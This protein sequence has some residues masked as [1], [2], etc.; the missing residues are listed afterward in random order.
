MSSPLSR[1]TCLRDYEVQ[2][3]QRL[4][5]GT[6]AYLNAGGAD[7]L[8]HIWNEQ[9]FKK[10]ALWPR[11][12]NN[13]G[14]GSTSLDLFGVRH[15]HPIFIA[16]MAYHGLA[17]AEAEHATAAAAAAMKAAFVVSTQASVPIEALSHR[18]AEGHLWFQLYLQDDRYVSL[19]LI[20]R[21]E[22]A[23]FKAIVITVDAPI[24]GSRNEDQR[25]AFQL[26]TA[27]QPVNLAPYACRQINTTLPAGASLF[28][29]PLIAQM[30]TWEAV[31]WLIRQ[32]RLPVLLKGILNPLDVAPALDTGAS[33]IVVSNHGGRVLDTLP[34]MLDCL[35][36]IVAEVRARVPVLADGGI[37]RGSDVFKA[38]ALGADAVL[39]GRP[40]LH[41]LAVAGSTGVA[42]VLNLLLGELEATMVL[43]GCK[44]LSHINTSRLRWLDSTT[45]HELSQ[46]S[47][48]AQ[49]D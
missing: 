8:T 18:S 42:H 49:V 35:P 13:V 43:T 30:P 44:T 6:W 24:Q 5:A 29:H 22:R 34:A 10:I 17:H 3:R 45:R 7:G 28:Q 47:R 11:V 40:I 4:P 12:L 39:I 14:G 23:G 41:G 16:P 38:L 27:V 21:A 33:G 15:K 20:Q 1:L 19:D 2:A 32:T 31:A 9:A 48:H 36:G 46:P 37:R 25:Q 26:P